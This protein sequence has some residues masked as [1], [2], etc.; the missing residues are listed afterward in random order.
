MNQFGKVQWSKQAMKASSNTNFWTFIFLFK[1][2]PTE[3]NK[4]FWALQ[5]SGH[6]SPGRPCSGRACCMLGK[7]IGH[8]APKTSRKFSIPA[9]GGLS[10]VLLFYRSMNFSIIFLAYWILVIS[11]HMCESRHYR[12]GVLTQKEFEMNS[13]SGNQGSGWRR[14]DC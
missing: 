9:S 2:R 7:K 8:C 11:I 14:I 13:T 5:R 4:I 6:F 10:G 3:I 1:I 12:G